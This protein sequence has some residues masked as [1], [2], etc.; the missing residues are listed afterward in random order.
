MTRCT[1]IAVANST[2][3]RFRKVRRIIALIMEAVSS[4]ETSVTLYQTAQRNILQD[5]HFHTRCRENLIFHY[6][7]MIFF[8][9]LAVLSWCSSILLGETWLLHWNMLRPLLPHAFQFHQIRPFGHN[10]RRWITAVVD[11]VSLNSLRIRFTKLNVG[12]RPRIFHLELPS[13]SPP[14]VRLRAD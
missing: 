13:P 11:T 10:T 5:S 6:V 3:Y 14:R 12:R 9:L 2:K 4:S 1:T 7:F 8:S